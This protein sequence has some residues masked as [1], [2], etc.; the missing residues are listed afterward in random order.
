MNPADFK[1]KVTTNVD[2]V[3]N[4][5]TGIAPQYL[6]EEVTSISNIPSN[7]MSQLSILVVMNSRDTGPDIFW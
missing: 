2:N 1:H 3:I 4:R 6:S 5:I 7:V